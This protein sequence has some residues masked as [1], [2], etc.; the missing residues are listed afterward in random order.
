MKPWRKG[1]TL[2][3]DEWALME[4]VL[5]FADLFVDQILLDDSLQFGAHNLCR[6]TAIS[7]KTGRASAIFVDPHDTSRPRM[8]DDGLFTIAPF[9]LRMGLSNRYYRVQPMR[10]G[11]V[12]LPPEPDRPPLPNL[13]PLLHAQQHVRYQW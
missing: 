6:I 10:P 4:R 11:I 13:G 1:G 5:S 8:P 2:D 3:L 7:H 9:D 12:S